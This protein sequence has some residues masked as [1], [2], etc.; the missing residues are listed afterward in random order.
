MVRIEIE[1]VDGHRELRE[2]MVPRIDLCPI[3]MTEQ[4][5]AD[6]HQIADEHQTEKLEEMLFD[7]SPGQTVPP[8]SGFIFLYQSVATDEK[9]YGYAIVAQEG[10]EMDEQVAV[11][12]EELVEKLHRARWVELILV[13]LYGEAK[14]MAIIV[15]DDSEYGNAAQ[16]R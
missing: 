13:F 12:G 16:C 4:I 5:D 8:R 14:E 9:E 11:E 3:A 6:E 10:E 15:Q 1:K 2:Y 7:E